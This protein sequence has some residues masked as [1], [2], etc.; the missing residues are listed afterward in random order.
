MALAGH[1]AEDALIPRWN[2]W[3][4]VQAPTA[5]PSFLLMHSWEAD[6]G[7]LN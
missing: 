1:L 4:Q 7:D 3:V 6:M 5:G 2:V